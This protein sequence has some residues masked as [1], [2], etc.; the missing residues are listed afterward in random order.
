MT[1]AR[2]LLGL[3][4]LASVAAAATPPAVTLRD[5]RLTVRFEQ[6]PLAD[7][8]TAIAQAGGGVVRG[9]VREPRDV[10]TEFDAVPLTDALPRLLGAQNFTLSYAKDGRLL[11]IVLLGGPDVTPPTAVATGST[12]TTTT[13]PAKA[14]FPLELSRAFTKHRPVKLPEGG[15]LQFED[16]TATFPELLEVATLDDDGTMRNQATQVV[17]SALERESRLRRSF[18][19]TLYRLDP[20]ALEGIMAGESGERFVEI[21]EYLSVHS[22][23]A[24]LQRKATLVLDQMR[25]TGTAH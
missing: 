2:A 12:T 8:L 10:T 7:A 16:G 17:L 21:V 5:D 14:A 24:N 25:T 15:T 1:M 3:V 22:R 11:A 19:R 20:P 23:D 9:S 6:V 18:L 4:L 13:L